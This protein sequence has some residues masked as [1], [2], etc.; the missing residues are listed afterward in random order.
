VDIFSGGS[1]REHLVRRTNVGLPRASGS[2]A[3][4]TIHI[5]AHAWT[6]GPTPSC[7]GD[8]HIGVI[9]TSHSPAWVCD[10]FHADNPPASQGYTWHSGNTFHVTSGSCTPQNATGVPQG[11]SVHGHVSP[12]GSDVRGSEI[13]AGRIGH[14]IAIQTNCND[15]PTIFP[16]N[17]S[18]DHSCGGSSSNYPHYGD[19]LW[20]DCTDA[21]IDALPGPAGSD[22]HCS[23]D[24]GS[25]AGSMDANVKIMYRALHDYG[26]Y[27]VDNGYGDTSEGFVVQVDD[28]V[29]SIAEGHTG[30][31]ETIMAREGVASITSN[32]GRMYRWW[33]SNSS[34]SGYL[35]SAWWAHHLHML[36]PCVA[37]GSC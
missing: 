16:A 17:S 13:L 30:P 1:K 33:L 7:T 35:G 20:L 37:Q 12:V 23:H 18:A 21:E 11:A 9:D 2:V 5:P 26:A 19:H 27:D 29:V 14:A 25:N 22:T 10:F 4:T 32:Y 28:D 3:T 31:W 24:V 34:Q 8:C 36:Q 6:E 15:N